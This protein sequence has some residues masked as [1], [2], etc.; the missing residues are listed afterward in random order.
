M[1]L[2]ELGHLSVQQHARRR[3]P[4]VRRRR[5]RLRLLDGLGGGGLGGGAGGGLG[6]A[7]G[8]DA[9]VGLLQNLEPPG[10]V[11]LSPQLQPQLGL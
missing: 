9:R 3:V 1:Q 8:L 11:P 4:A 5:Q 6:A 10:Q 2:R 7:L